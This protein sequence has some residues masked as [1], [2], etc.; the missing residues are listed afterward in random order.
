MHARIGTSNVTSAAHRYRLA[1]VQSEEEGRAGGP[2]GA[3]D[4]AM[5]GSSVASE[6][7]SK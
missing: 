2:S 3:G 7:P 1:S 6:F 4:E 5:A